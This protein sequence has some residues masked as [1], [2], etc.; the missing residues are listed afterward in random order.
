MRWLR[1]AIFVKKALG[2]L[3]FFR[4]SPEAARVALEGGTDASDA[5]LPAGFLKLSSVISGGQ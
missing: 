3:F 4:A 1:S 2:G 5:Q